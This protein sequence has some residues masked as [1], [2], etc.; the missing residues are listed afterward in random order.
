[1]GLSSLE[2]F[3]RLI[4]YSRHMTGYYYYFTNMSNNGCQAVSS[5]LVT[6]GCPGPRPGD[7]T[8]SAKVS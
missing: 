4:K 3:V 5:N 8:D 7:R 2:G 6:S 1:M